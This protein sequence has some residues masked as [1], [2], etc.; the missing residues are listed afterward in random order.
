MQQIIYLRRRYMELINEIH[1]VY[2]K[3]FA[4][5]IVIVYAV[6]LMYHFAL[7]NVHVIAG[8]NL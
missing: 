5:V 8:I 4:I 6:A 7:V 3:V 1:K 2:L